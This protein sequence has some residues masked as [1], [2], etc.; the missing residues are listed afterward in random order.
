MKV[1][2]PGHPRIVLD[3]HLDEA[4]LTQLFS[5][6][7]R[8]ANFARPRST[9]K[10]T[11]GDDEDYHHILQLVWED[12]ATLVTADRHFFK[13]VRTFQADLAKRRKDRCF[14][15]VLI[16]SHIRDEQLR[17][18]GGFLDGSMQVRCQDCV[19]ISV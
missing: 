17:T 5:L 9:Y 1:A 7:V 2:R 18:L 19:R 8:S 11:H 12:Y 14:N 15:G 4:A 3:K 13:K 16:V 10:G 6:V